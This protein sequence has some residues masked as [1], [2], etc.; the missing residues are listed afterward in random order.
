M[1][2]LFALYMNLEFQIPTYNNVSFDNSNSNNEKIHCTP[3]NSMIHK[4]L[5]VPKRMDYENIVY[6]IAPSQNFHNLSLFQYKHLEDLK[7]PTLF[8]G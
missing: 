1:A 6:S 7:I 4:F 3:I 2:T 5:D 8:Y